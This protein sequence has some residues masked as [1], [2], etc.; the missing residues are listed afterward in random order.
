[1][2]SFLSFILSISVN[3]GNLVKISLIV[4]IERIFAAQRFFGNML[5]ELAQLCRSIL[6]ELLRSSL[7]SFAK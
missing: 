6:T 4:H 2:S 5:S 1:M 3:G 7:A